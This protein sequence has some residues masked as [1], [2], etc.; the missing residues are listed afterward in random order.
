M[1]SIRQLYNI[2]DYFGI[3]MA[4]F[5]GSGAAPLRRAAAPNVEFLG[6][7]SDPD[8]LEL[9][10]NCRFLLFP[11]EEDYGIVPLEAMACGRPVVAFGRGG[12]T[13]TVVDGETGVFF[14]EQTPE[15]LAD[16]VARAESIR[17]DAA[18][19]RARAE[20]FSIAR[21]RESMAEALS[22]CLCAQSR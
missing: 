1:P 4:E 20:E 12:A 6:W 21:F 16:A 19:I 2:A 15:A 17:W 13:E 3:S 14:G 5:F 11:G 9:Y 10:R 18:A 22:N 8:V 7:R